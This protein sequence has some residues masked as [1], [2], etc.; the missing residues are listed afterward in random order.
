M[1]TLALTLLAALSLGGVAFAEEGGAAVPAA[2]PAK[3]AEPAP[4]SSATTAA[5]T[6]TNEEYPLEAHH[7]PLV[8]P[9][10]MAEVSGGGEYSS[11]TA[12]ATGGATTKNAKTSVG[13]SARYGIVERLEAGLQSGYGLDPKAEWGKFLGLHVA[14]LAMDTE[15]L[16]LA[17]VV[18]TNFD[19]NDGRDLFNGVQ[20]GANTRYIITDQFYVFGGN[21][22]IDI[23]TKPESEL[24]LNLEAGLGFQ[25]TEQLA[26]DASTSLAHLKLSGDHNKNT[27]IGDATPLDLRAL[28]AI[29]HMLDAVVGVKFGDVQNAGD[30][31]AITGGVNFRI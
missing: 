23:V 26:L 22:L 21:D 3:A 12:T 24:S 16:D 29:S 7:R 28:F 27:N 8:L 1:R 25:A 20:L 10:G 17:G 18:S 19:F 5:P 13:V 2:E 30:D 15:K 31:Y 11:Q 6:S 9:R 4:P 14:Y